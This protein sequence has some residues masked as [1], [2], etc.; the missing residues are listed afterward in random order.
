MHSHFVGAGENALVLEF[1]Y[2]KAKSLRYSLSF[3]NSLMQK[4]VPTINMHNDTKSTI[5]QRKEMSAHLMVLD[6]SFKKASVFCSDS[7]F[8]NDDTSFM[9]SAIVFY[10]ISTKQALLLLQ[11]TITVTSLFLIKVQDYS[12]AVC[13]RLPKLKHGA[14]QL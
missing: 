11:P 13:A 3:I 9:M 12:R 1:K 4:N 2:F 6:F 7:F 10:F 5:Q 14:G 8:K